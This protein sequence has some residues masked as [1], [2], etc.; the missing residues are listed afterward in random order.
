MKIKSIK[1]KN[2]KVLIVPCNN[3]HLKIVNKKTKE[4]T[5]ILKSEGIKEVENLLLHWFYVGYFQGIA[6]KYGKVARCYG[7]AKKENVIQFPIDKLRE[8]LE[9][10]NSLAGKFPLCFSLLTAVRIM[11]SVEPENYNERIRVF[12]KLIDCGIFAIKFFNG[13]TPYYSR[14]E[15][16]TR[17]KASILRRHFHSMDTLKD[18][19]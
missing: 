4:L 3:K 11:K 16:N 18:L 15:I 5:K 19:I 10:Y 17:S 1:I 2:N 12:L 6:T 8:I 14:C 7:L 13:A 9:E